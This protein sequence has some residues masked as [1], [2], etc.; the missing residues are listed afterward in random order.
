MSFDW[1]DFPMVQQQDVHFEH[2][3]SYPSFEEEKT[4]S[5]HHHVPSSGRDLYLVS[6]SS[7]SCTSPSSSKR[8]IFSSSLEI[9]THSP[10]A[11]GDHPCCKS[12]SVDLSSADYDETQ[13][14]DLSCWLFIV[15]GF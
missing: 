13:R 6:K 10:I 2:F 12:L 5:R 3:A 8:D 7:S 14:T 9:R 4:S 1:S 15:L 11:V